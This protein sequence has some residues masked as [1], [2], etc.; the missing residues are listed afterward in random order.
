MATVPREKL[1]ADVQ[2]QGAISD[3]HCVKDALKTADYDEV[4][5]RV[6][7]ADMFGD[8]NNFEVAV[9]KAAA[10]AW[11]AAAAAAAEAAAAA[12]AAAQAAA[13]EATLLRAKQRKRDRQAWQDLGT[14]VRRYA[15]KWQVHISLQQCW[16]AQTAG[17]RV[18]HLKGLLRDVWRIWWQPTHI[19][20]AAVDQH[21]PN[22]LLPP[23]LLPHAIRLS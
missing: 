17:Q 10:D 21:A 3:F 1:L 15:V 22:C 7:D 16:C 5:L 6:N 20:A 23:M 13:D 8:G 12:A 11:H 18:C 4:L 2:F 19:R 9:T 14:E